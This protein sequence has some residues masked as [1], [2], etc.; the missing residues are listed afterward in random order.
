MLDDCKASLSKYASWLEYGDELSGDDPDGSKAELDDEKYGDHCVNGSVDTCSQCVDSDICSSVSV[1][2][3]LA[4][5]ER[6]MSMCNCGDCPAC[7]AKYNSYDDVVASNGAVTEYDSTAIGMAEKWL[8]ET[9][10]DDFVGSNTINVV[11]QLLF[12]LIAY[13]GLANK[14]RK[15]LDDIECPF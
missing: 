9:A 14:H 15:M 12:E 1:I 10:I 2:D 6:E 5:G 4:F 7:L 13:K 3:T 11:Q 8:K